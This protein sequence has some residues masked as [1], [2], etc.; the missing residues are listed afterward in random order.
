MPAHQVMR[1][2]EM[3]PISA[4]KMTRASMTSAETM[5]TPMV[6]ATCTPNNRKAMKLKNAAH[7]TA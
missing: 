4:P 5:P 7:T 2:Q 1:F 6:R 3:P